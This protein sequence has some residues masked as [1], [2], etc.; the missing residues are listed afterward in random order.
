[1]TIFYVK[2]WLFIHSVLYLIIAFVASDWAW[3]LA[4]A[5]WDPMYRLIVVLLVL[6]ANATVFAER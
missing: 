1:M 6:L 4:T 5:D 3:P 2:R